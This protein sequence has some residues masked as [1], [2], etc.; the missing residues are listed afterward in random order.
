MVLARAADLGA[1]IGSP[2]D[3]L[4]KKHILSSGQTR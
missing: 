2:L 1:A 4:L 3:K